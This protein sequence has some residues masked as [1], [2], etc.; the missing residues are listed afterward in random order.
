MKRIGVLC[1]LALASAFAL[2]PE[3]A[4]AS[5]HGARL[6]RPGVRRMGLFR[7]GARGRARS[8]CC[9]PHR[10]TRP[11]HPYPP[12]TTYPDDVVCPQS[13]LVNH[14]AYSTYLADSC[15]TGGNKC[16]IDGPTNWSP[17][18][19]LNNPNCQPL[20]SSCDNLYA[21]GNLATNGIPASTAV[22]SVVTNPVTTAIE[23]VR[24]L[25]FDVTVGGTTTPVTAQVMTIKWRPNATS[26]FSVI[27]HHGYQISNIA[28]ANNATT[29]AQV[30]AKCWRVNFTSGGVTTVYQIILRN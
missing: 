8:R 28:M 30:G 6:R 24:V 5:C 21:Q 29:K 3:T 22:S 1:L 2:F 23:G 19:C 7:L 10:P 25:R 18:G 11:I 12:P 20:S 9:S 14:G 15:P 17:L 26:P 16:T 13:E 4:E 27:A